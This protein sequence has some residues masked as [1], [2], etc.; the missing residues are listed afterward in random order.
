MRIL[1]RKIR[2]KRTNLKLNYLH[3]VEMSITTN[4]ANMGTLLPYLQFWV[5]HLIFFLQTVQGSIHICDLLG[6]NY[7]VDYLLNNGLYCT[8]WVHLHLIFGQLL[9]R[10]KS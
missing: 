9:H 4:P 8:K 3:K 5:T 2:R 7:R 1:S 10:L 6:V